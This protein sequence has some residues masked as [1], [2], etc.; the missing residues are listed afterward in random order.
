MLRIMRGY[1]AVAKSL[2]IGAQPI[3][4]VGHGRSGT[5]WIANVLAQASGAI[6]YHEPCRPRREF[7]GGINTWFKYLRPST[8]DR[9]FEAYLDPA[10]KGLILE[11]GPR[12]S[13]RVCLR[14]L[15]PGYQIIVK[16]V[17]AMMSTEWVWDRYEPKILVITRHPCGVCASEHNKRTPTTESVRAILDNEQLVEAH[18]GD[19]VELLKSAREP[20]EIYGAVWGARHRVLYDQY[21]RNPSWKVASYEQVARDPVKGFK[22]LY[23][24]FDLR[25]SK[26][27]ESFLSQTTTSHVEGLYEIKRYTARTYNRWKEIME[28][29]EVD[30]VRAFVQPFGLPI[31]NKMEDWD[32]KEY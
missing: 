7:G 28:Q 6:Y 25:W 5:T 27:V 18:L 12:F 24:Q 19:Y 16:E 29:K 2:Q 26:R 30:Q 17:A 9:E 14:R 32:V 31:Y 22:A 13:L 1:N 11:R 15:L 8:P 10:F 21:K 4:V 20:Y 3:F 23:A